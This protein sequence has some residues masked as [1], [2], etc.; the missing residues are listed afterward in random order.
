MFVRLRYGTQYCTLY[1]LVD[2]QADNGVRYRRRGFC[3]QGI[4]GR[5]FY[6][7]QRILFL[8]YLV[9][10][11]S[12]TLNCLLSRHLLPTLFCLKQDTKLLTSILVCCF[13]AARL[14]FGCDITLGGF[15]PYLATGFCPERFPV[16]YPR[17]PLQPYKQARKAY[18]LKK[19]NIG[20]FQY[21]KHQY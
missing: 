20:V 19:K 18:E 17:C 16:C 2:T 9:F 6:K 3:V 12:M 15:V 4:K 1:T 10:V 8:L 13:N 14:Y 21:L 7:L 5:G 11:L